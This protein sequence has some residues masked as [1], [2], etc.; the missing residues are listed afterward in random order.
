MNL[1]KIINIDGIMTLF[2]YTNDVNKRMYDF[3]HYP[4]STEFRSVY[5]AL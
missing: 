5:K 1:K 2:W 4:A 3:S